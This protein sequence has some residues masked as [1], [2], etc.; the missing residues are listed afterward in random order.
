PLRGRRRATTCGA[1]AC[2]RRAQSL[3]DGM[4]LAS[5]L[6]VGAYLRRCAREGASAVLVRR[7]DGERGAIYI[8]VLRLDGTALLFSPSPAGLSASDDE[9]R[10]QATLAE[11]WRSEAEVDVF[12]AR[13]IDNDPDLWVLAVEDPQGRHFLDDWLVRA[14]PSGAPG[15][16]PWR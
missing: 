8:K 6:W 10:W 13:Q 4:R 12:L 15:T 5:Q 16:T 14:Q 3:G 1:R 7:G 9:R 2:P 11:A